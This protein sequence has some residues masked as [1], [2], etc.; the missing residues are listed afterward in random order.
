MSKLTLQDLQNFG[1]DYDLKPFHNAKS[2][3]V[4]S[5]AETPGPAA[6]EDPLQNISTLEELRAYMN[7]FE[8]CELKEEA[9]QMVFSDGVPDAPIMFI[10][11]APGAEE[12]KLG[13]PFVGQSGQLLDK[14]LAFVGLSRAKNIYI[15][16]MVPWR[17]PGNRTPTTDEIAICRPMLMKHIALIKPKVIA[18]LGAT[19]FKGVLGMKEGMLKSRGRWHE[20]NDPY[21]GEPIPCMPLFHPAYLLRAAKQKA[22]FWQDLLTLK[23]HLE[24]HG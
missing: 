1:V 2:A 17:P 3:D 23:K 10:G 4:K 20:L 16:N 21:L 15:A 13:K 19:P 18:F 22:L 8:A 7:A 11:E 24:K 9:T 5:E 14:F 6:V 12:D